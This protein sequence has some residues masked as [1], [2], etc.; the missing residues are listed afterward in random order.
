ME[1]LLESKGLYQIT[2][3]FDATPLTNEKCTKCL[4]CNDE[5]RGI[6]SMIFEDTEFHI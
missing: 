6:T 3:C 1:D 2:L 5:V 4:N